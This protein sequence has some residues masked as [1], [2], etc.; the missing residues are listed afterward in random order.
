MRN[1]TNNI[2]KITNEIWLG[3]HGE[4]KRLLLSLNPHS[5][6]S[7][8]VSVNTINEHTIYKRTPFDLAFSL[9]YE[10]VVEKLAPH[11]SAEDLKTALYRSITQINTKLFNCLLKFVGDEDLLE[12]ELKAAFSTAEILALPL[13]DCKYK[14]PEQEDILIQKRVADFCNQTLRPMLLRK[15]LPLDFIDRVCSQTNFPEN[16]M[17]IIQRETLNAIVKNADQSGQTKRKI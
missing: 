6:F 1:Y 8:N 13:T 7:W 5:T 4:A 15:N 2:K 14:K 10:D 16:Q 11:Q 9:S 17:D 3:N 12:D